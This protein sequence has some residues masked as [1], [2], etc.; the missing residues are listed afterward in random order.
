MILSLLFLGTSYTIGQY[1]GAALI[2]IACVLDV[3]PAFEA[4]QSSSGS[5]NS[6]YWIFVF[7]AGTVPFAV[8]MVYK[9]VVFR[10]I[11][12][13]IFY[14][15]AADASYQLI[16]TLILTPVDAI[17]KIGSSS[18]LE[19]VY[20]NM[21]DGCKCMFG[22]NSLSGDDCNGVWLL[23]LQYVLFNIAINLCLL[24]LIQR[25]SAAFMFLAMTI[26]VPTANLCFTFTFIMGSAAQP[27]SIWDII[28]LVLI[29]IGLLMYRFFSP[30]AE[31]DHLSTD[32]WHHDLDY[33]TTVQGISSR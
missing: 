11:K 14:L 32:K 16:C 6:P 25:G 5:G 3:I 23:L 8:S 21:W 18:S 20:V 15:M 12:M 31:P 10:D 4:D 33:N 22:Y 2:C 19:D 17:P 28:A 13:S 27:L 9:E 1:S 24:Y 30:P 29:V 7:I 26:T